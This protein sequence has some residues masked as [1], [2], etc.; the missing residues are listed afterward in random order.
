VS[1]SQSVDE[2]GSGKERRGS[3]ARGQMDGEGKGKGAEAAAR[4]G[5]GLN[6]RGSTKRAKHEKWGM[7]GKIAGPITSARARGSCLVQTPA[8]NCT[9]GGLLP[10]G[11]G[12]EK[13]RKNALAPAG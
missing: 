2:N 3:A 4:A 12:T 11:P 5:V 6:T 7:P 10:L 8:A 13:G 9:I 1:E